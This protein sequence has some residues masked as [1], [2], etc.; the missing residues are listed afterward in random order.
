M[1][2]NK[3]V[4]KLFAC[5]LIALTLISSTALATTKSFSSA[6]GPYKMYYWLIGDDRWLATDF[7][8][9]SIYWYD[10]NNQVP[11]TYY[12]TYTLNVQLKAVNGSTYTTVGTSGPQN[13]NAYVQTYKE[14]DAWSC[15][16]HVDSIYGW[17]E[18][19][20]SVWCNG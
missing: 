18:W 5:T 4:R 10:T 9:G 1:K 6:V 8:Q 19:Q 16:F 13:R 14:V 7:G 17:T 12:N 3:K 20:D 11:V 2:R 15:W